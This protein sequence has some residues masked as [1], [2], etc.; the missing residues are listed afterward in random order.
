MQTQPTCCL[1]IANV[2]A[3]A[4]YLFLVMRRNEPR[5]VFEAWLQSVELVDGEVTRCVADNVTETLR[6]LL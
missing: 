3:R 1:A 4:E 2:Y 5:R 6:W